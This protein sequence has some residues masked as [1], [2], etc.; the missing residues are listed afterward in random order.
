[1]AAAG[2]DQLPAQVARQA[3][4]LS[5]GLAG[6]PGAVEDVTAR[7]TGQAERL[8]GLRAATA[9]VL[10]GNT[11]MA[12]AAAQARAIASASLA[13]AVGSIGALTTAVLSV[14]ADGVLLE[15]AL[16]S[17]G[18]VAQS[19]EAMAAHTRMLALNAAIEAEH[20]GAAGRGFAVVA[21]EVRAMALRAADASA[22]IRATVEAVRTSAKR[23]IEHAQGSSAQAQAAQDA[24]GGVL[25]LLGD[26]RARFGEIAAVADQIAAGTQEVAAKCGDLDRAI[27]TMA[28]EASASSG[29]LE[30][31]RDG[32]VGLVGISELLV[33]SA[34]TDGAVTDDT[35]IILRVQR[36]ALAVAALFEAA[37]LSG[38]T[39][40]A[41]LF[42]IDYQPIAGS[43]PPQ[44]MSRFVA[45]TDRLLPPLLDGVLA[46]DAKFVLCIVVDRN[47]YCPTHNQAASQPQGPDLVWNVANCRNRR[48]FDDRNGLRSAR[49]Q[50]PF[51][52]QS[53]RRHMG[54]GRVVLIQDVSSP[55]FVNGRHWGAARIAYDTIV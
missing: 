23:V 54:G 45:L 35:P 50:T 38:D 10:Q 22:E 32:L 9:D 25:R 14:A 16:A 51:L 19:M 11:A 3:S 29:D 47:G 37:L 52:L 27:T 48:M 7:V 2:S 43:N 13:A 53:Y 12:A 24:G 1:M 21:A 55:I 20:A 17:I 31:A 40:V 34:T 39:S 41:E 4:K 33:V 42:D 49:A 30:R 6:V 8:G 18:L 26:T 46:S 15:Q 36:T 5:L 44:L 28:A